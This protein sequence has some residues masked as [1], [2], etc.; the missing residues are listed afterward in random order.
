MSPVAN[1]ALQPPPGAPRAQWPNDRGGAAMLTRPRWETRA[2]VERHPHGGDW[3][4]DL[5]FGLNDGLVTTL[6]FLMTVSAVAT[7][8]SLIL[9]ALGEVL[10]GGVSMGLGGLLSART[11]REVLENRIATERHEITHEPAEERAEL[12]EIYH[13]KGFRGALLDRV[14]M[15]LTSDRE[16]WLRAMVQDELGV[17][18][19]DEIV[20][21]RSGLLIGGAFMV[22]GLIPT[23]PL[24]LGLAHPRVWAY[25]LTALAA[26]GLGALKARYTLK[27][28]LRSGIEFLLVVT[29]G[30]A[31]GV[32]LGALL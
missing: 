20:P 22:G 1:A 25:V 32:V 10:A 24:L 13:R 15:F 14:V 11:D 16:R 3:L 28:P 12:R 4:R 5:V 18:E 27:G 23:L 19:A 31:V 30:A 8:S 2:A 7:G 29:A 9:I 6:V 17:V 26:L 21:W